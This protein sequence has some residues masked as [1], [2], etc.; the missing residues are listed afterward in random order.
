MM[1]ELK[2]RPVLSESEAQ[3]NIKSSLDVLNK[4]LSAYPDLQTTLAK[5]LRFVLEVTHRSGGMILI[6]GPDDA[7]PL[8]WIIEGAPDD[9]VTQAKKKESMLRMFCRTWIQPG[10]LVVTA[11]PFSPVVIFPLPMATGQQGILLINGEEPSRM[12]S[13]FLIPAS[14]SLAHSVCLGR[15]GAML[16]E[17]SKLLDT[18]GMI[19]YGLDPRNSF[20]E[21]MYNL[22]KGLR[23]SFTCEAVSLVML[24][25]NR[26]G[27][28]VKKTLT[29]APDWI[30]Q[31]SVRVEDGLIG[32]CF[33]TRKSILSNEPQNDERF[34]PAIDAVPGVEIHSLLCVPIQTEDDIVGVLAF[35]NKRPG[36]FS[37]YDQQL[38]TTVA[39]SVVNSLVAL[40]TIQ[41][42]RVLN[43]QLEASRWELIRSRNTLRSLFDNLPEAMYIID[44]SYRLI[45]V[46]R[47]RAGRTKDE[48]SILV[49]K[50][51]YE[52]LFGRSE[53]CLGCLV[54]ETFYR[55]KVTN[56]M[57]RQWEGVLEPLEWEINSYPIIDESDEVNQVILVEKD[58]TDKRRLEGFLTQSEKMAAV[59]ELAAGIAHEINNPLT[60]ILANAQILERELP[61]N[62]DWRELVDLISR[63]GT[64]ALHA[65]KGLLNFT[66]KEQF[67]F[68]PT[69]VNETIERSLEMVRHELVTRGINLVYEPGENLP[70]LR[71]SPNHVQGV[72]LNL[73]M[74]AMD[75]MDK[76]EKT[77]RII[78]YQQAN[79]VCVSVIDNGQGIAPEKLKRI[80]EPFFT[81]KERDR[82]TGLGLSVCHR[83]IK[84]HGGLILVDSQ[85]GEGT[86]F[87]V[88]LPAY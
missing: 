56:R 15:N 73:V 54:A 59:G 62:E 80:F 72:W 33:Q 82:G 2:D 41:Q 28:L 85:I 27:M 58:V 77:I 9:W 71:A 10:G 8:F 39:R 24:D 87:N 69:D 29:E 49:G 84:Q 79:D 68:V 50:I 6:Q 48:P 43:A 42:Y 7:E 32:E 88:V 25:K 74:N 57:E 38:L 75:A 78:S 76:E 37:L 46:N 1:A 21:A 81:T 53:P 47:V 14:E 40:Q 11:G 60:V 35:Q 26:G 34:N 4:L 65:V 45:A 44:R 17:I 83:V 63:A 31:V 52:A 22:V 12:E 86:T 18:L 64:R 70:L 23:E 67:E 36:T 5:A 19:I 13:E 20:D 16:F 3:Q 66:R 51:C 30:Y 61:P 55:R